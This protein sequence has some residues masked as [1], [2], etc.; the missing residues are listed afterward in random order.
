MNFEK[1]YEPQTIR[2]L[3]FA[4]AA[5]QQIVTKYA[6]S[7]PSKHLVLFGEP[8]AGKTVTARVIAKERSRQFHQAQDYLEVNGGQFTSETLAK[9]GGFQ[10]FTRLSDGPVTVII[11]EIN[12]LDPTQMSELRAILDSNQDLSIIATTNETTVATKQHN[13]LKKA[14][15]NRFLELPLKVPPLN[16][17]ISR[18]QA[19]LQAEGY[20]WTPQQVATLL[21]GSDSSARDIILKI[22]LSI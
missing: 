15:Y 3:V 4:D 20:N 9:I 13:M 16:A 7:Y 19:I 2:D 14:F 8:G 10:N 22:E 18:A 17:W 11:N 1:K 5:A 12:L 21:Q 6:N